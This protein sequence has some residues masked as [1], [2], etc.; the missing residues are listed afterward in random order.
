MRGIFVS[1]L[2]CALAATAFAEPT[3]PT[4]LVAE[5]ATVTC[6]SSRSGERLFTCADR[7]AKLR[8]GG[9]DYD[10]LDSIF[11]VASEEHL[12]VKEAIERTVRVDVPDG[13]TRAMYW[14]ELAAR[15]DRKLGRAVSKSYR[16]TLPGSGETVY[17]FQGMKRFGGKAY[18]LVILPGGEVLS[19]PAEPL[20][21]LGNWVVHRDRL[22][23]KRS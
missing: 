18:L 17:V 22:A 9:V 19:G 5:K 12:L 14:E 1:A 15:I 13:E 21:D 8:A 6:G 16:S 7:E 10:S 20:E 2:L 11:G 4:D 3:C 23:A